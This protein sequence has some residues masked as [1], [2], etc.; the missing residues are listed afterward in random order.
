ML[1]EFVHGYRENDKRG[2]HTTRLSNT[3]I[4]RRVSRRHMKNNVFFPTASKYQTCLISSNW[5]E[6][7][8]KSAPFILWNRSTP[9]AQNLQTGSDFQ[10]LVQ[11][12]AHCK[13]DQES[14]SVFQP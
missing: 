1:A 14:R 5:T 3:T 8:K 2:S 10:Q 4:S 9:T 13:S 12:P 7:K 6:A 11:P